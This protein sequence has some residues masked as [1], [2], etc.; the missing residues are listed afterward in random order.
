MSNTDSIRPYFFAL[1]D[2]RCFFLLSIIALTNAAKIFV[3][4]SSWLVLGKPLMFLH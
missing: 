2:P 3:V 1:L 4:Y